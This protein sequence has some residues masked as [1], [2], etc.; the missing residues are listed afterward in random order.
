MQEKNL[1]VYAWFSRC[2]V[3]LLFMALLAVFSVAAEAGVA[4]EKIEFVVDRE[5]YYVDG[6]EFTV[7]VAPFIEGGRTYVPVRYLGDSLGAS[8]DWEAEEEKVTLAKDGDIVELIIGS[9][10]LTVNGEPRSVDVPPLIREG[11]TYLPA[12]HV[13]ESFGYS[14]EWEPEARAVQITPRDDE[15]VEPVPDVPERPE[16]SWGEDVQIT[17]TGTDSVAPAV[18]VN[19]SKVHVCWVDARH[20]PEIREIYYI[21][22]SDIGETWSAEETRISQ[23]E[24]LSIRPSFAAW[25]D[26]V[27]LF[28]RDDRHE[29][30]E[31]YVAKSDDGGASWGPE[32][33]LTEDPGYSGCPFPV[34]IENEVHIFW[35][36]N[37]EGTFQI[38]HKY[39]DDFGDS[40]S[41]DTNLTPEGEQAEFSYPAVDGETIHLVWRDFRAGNAEIYYKRSEDGGLTWTDDQRLTDDPG[42]SEHPKLV[43][44]GDNL[45]LVWRDNRDGSYE[46]Y[47]KKSTDGGRNWSADTKLTTGEGRSLWPVPALQ[48][49]LL[50][51]IWCEEREEGQSLYYMSS[52]DGGASWSEEEK[53]STALAPFDIMGTFPLAVEGNL[54]HVLF[55][56]DRTG[57]IEVY[58]KQGVLSKP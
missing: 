7:D 12:R 48:G 52:P 4:G 5:S 19:G 57:S 17:A 35:R 24:S 1:D 56:D 23:A 22:S 8:V 51:L 31:V 34:V 49:E 21:Q 26:D 27:L 29:N 55:V 33:R 41:E 42:Q 43:A 46:I 9:E 15:I 50:H 6:Q 54:L 32:T 39:S 2:C 18:A 40:W 37:R 25:G 28:W 53:L 36:D 11:R 45:Y 20:G 16:F 30:F 14:V 10:T 47:F 13:A 58:Y 44:Q 38:H 3:F